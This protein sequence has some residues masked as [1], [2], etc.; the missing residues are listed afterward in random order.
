MSFILLKLL[1]FLIEGHEA[2]Q[3]S[4]N[5]TKAKLMEKH[6][7]KSNHSKRTTIEIE[8]QL[9]HLTS[10]SER[11]KDELKS[12]KKT[13]YEK[14][15]LLKN[16]NSSKYNSQLKIQQNLIKFNTTTKLKVPLVD[17]IELDTVLNNYNVI[18]GW[19]FT[20]SFTFK[21]I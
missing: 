12:L 17:G 21:H 7:N 11:V 18:N 2:A 16:Y 8:D 20:F 9:N 1:F 15:K 13:K 4:T 10:I 6:L 19:V 14:I 5:L 3:I